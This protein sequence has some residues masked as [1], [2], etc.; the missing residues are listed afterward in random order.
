MFGKK[1]YIIF[2]PISVSRISKFPLDR[3]HPESNWTDLNPSRDRSWKFY[4]QTETFF[5]IF[6]PK[7]N[8]LHPVPNADPYC[9]KPAAYGVKFHHHDGQNMRK[10][11]LVLFGVENYVMGLDHVVLEHHFVPYQKATLLSI[12]RTGAA[13]EF[14]FSGGEYVET[15]LYTTLCIK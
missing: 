2:G 11:Y 6:A 3:F 13:L 8:R 12:L 9:E 14:R 4:P 15:V 5:N 7:P 1:L 10:I